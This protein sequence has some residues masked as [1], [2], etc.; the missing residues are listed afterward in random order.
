MAMR[1]ASLALLL[2]LLSAALS[3]ATALQLTGKGLAAAARRCCTLQRTL[4]HLLRLRCLPHRPPHHPKHVAWRSIRCH[5]Q[6][7]H[8]R[9]QVLPPARPQGRSRRAPNRQ[10]RAGHHQRSFQKRPRRA[11]CWQR[12]LAGPGV[13]RAAGHCGRRYSAQPALCTD[14][15]CGDAAAGPVLRPGHLRSGRGPSCISPGE[16]GG[17]GLLASCDVCDCRVE[18]TAWRH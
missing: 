13:A 11:G 15:A 9:G 17:S 14:T 7:V 16:A 8:Q 10:R 12:V 2:T 1:G 6:L 4:P 5:I 18:N 3:A